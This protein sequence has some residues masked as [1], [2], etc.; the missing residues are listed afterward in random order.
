VKDFRSAKE[1]QKIWSEVHEA[2][3]A[4]FSKL[5]ASQGLE[6]RSFVCEEDFAREPQRYRFA[7]LLGRTTH[8]AYHAGRACGGRRPRGPSGNSGFF[9]LFTDRVLSGSIL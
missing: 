3:W 9:V 5:D 8:I 7:I 6:P 4:G 1:L 2:L